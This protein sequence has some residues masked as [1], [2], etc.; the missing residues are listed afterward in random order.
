MS[1][2]EQFFFIVVTILKIVF[3]SWLVKAFVR[4]LFRFLEWRFGDGK[5]AR[6]K[7][8]EADHE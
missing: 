4:Q 7:K 6:I 3:V 2:T 8:Q 1:Y 5:E